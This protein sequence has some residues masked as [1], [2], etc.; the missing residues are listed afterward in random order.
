MR[1][2]LYCIGSLPY[3]LAIMPR[4]RGADWLADDVRSLR[5][6]GIGVVVSFLTDE[7]QDELDLTEEQ[8]LCQAQQIELRR[9]P[10]E[11]RS[12]PAD[13][14]AFERLAAGVVEDLAL[15][16]EGFRHIFVLES[17]EEAVLRA[18]QAVPARGRGGAGAHR[19]AVE[20]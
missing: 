11:D 4:P 2:E 20:R 6:Q 12:V 7:E 8:E 10:V 19:A 1:A 14:D 16:R 13:A 15:K 5:E 3:R 9:F 18:S 17:E